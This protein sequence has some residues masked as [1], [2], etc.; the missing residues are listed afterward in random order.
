MPILKNVYFKIGDYIVKFF[1]DGIT[2][3]KPFRVRISWGCKGN[4]SYCIIKKAIGKL[5]SKPFTQCVSEFKKGLKEGYKKFIITGDDTSVYGQDIGSSF[6][7]LLDEIT[8]ITG[9]YEIS[10]LHINPGWIV[11]YADDL[12]KPLKR[13]KIVSLGIPIQSGCSRILQLMN[14]YYNVE[15]MKDAFI[16]IKNSSSNLLLTTTYIIGFPSETWDEFQETLN[17]IIETNFDSGV[18]YRFS[19]KEDTA[20]EK[21]KPKIPYDEISRRMNYA[22]KFLTKNG[23]KVFYSN[24]NNSILFDKKI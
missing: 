10:I 16:K 21:I 11:K 8:K 19:L 22:K 24:E 18:I 13:N 5:H 3:N 2:N 4:C 20:A 1:S 14:R 9:E 23:F 12:K 7:E 6:P 17:F 15:K